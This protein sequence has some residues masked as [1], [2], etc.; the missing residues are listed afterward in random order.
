MASSSFYYFFN[1]NHTVVMNS[2]VE[3]SASATPTR[4]CCQFLAVC[5]NSPHSFRKILRSFIIVLHHISLG[6]RVIL[7][8]CVT[9][10]LSLPPPYQHAHRY[11][12][13]TYIVS[14]QSTS[15]THRF[16]TIDL[17]RSQCSVASNITTMN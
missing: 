1:V 11:L 8:Q 3:H 15:M 2:C 16:P 6:H 10:P 9:Y 4:Y 5:F 7:A 14:S 17:Q 13:H 12:T